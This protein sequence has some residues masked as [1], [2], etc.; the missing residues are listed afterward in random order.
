MVLIFTFVHVSNGMEGKIKVDHLQWE[1][2]E[3]IGCKLALPKRS[4][5][6]NI[7]RDRLDKYWD[8]SGLLGDISDNIRALSSIMHI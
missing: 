7:Y 6:K 2:D 1:V 8:I 4:N 3:S 5:N